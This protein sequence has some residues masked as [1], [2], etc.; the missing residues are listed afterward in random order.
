MVSGSS[1]IA[2]WLGHYIADILFQTLPSIVAV[3]FI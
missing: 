1:L 2:Y 3:V